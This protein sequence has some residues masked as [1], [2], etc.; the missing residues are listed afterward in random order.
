M[1]AVDRF[2]SI[3]LQNGLIDRPAAHDKPGAL[4]LPTG[5]WRP[6]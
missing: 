4:E 6:A 5:R 1:A 3:A 2:G